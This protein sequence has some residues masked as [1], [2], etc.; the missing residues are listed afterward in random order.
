MMSPWW[1]V[2]SAFSV[3]S[4]RETRVKNGRLLTSVVL[5]LSQVWTRRRCS[6]YWAPNANVRSH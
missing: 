6:T 4:A 1:M 2:R 3:R 5:C